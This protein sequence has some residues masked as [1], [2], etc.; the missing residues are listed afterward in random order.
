M[1]VREAAKSFLEDLINKGY[2]SEAEV[3]RRRLH[4]G[5]PLWLIISE[6]TSLETALRLISEGSGVPMLGQHSLEDL[7]DVEAAR[8]QNP[9]T[10]KARRWLPLKDGRVAI[11]EPFGRLPHADLGWRELCLARP[12]DIDTTLNALFPPEKN[13][14]SKMRRLG[15]LLLDADVITEEELARALDEQGRSGGKLG[16]IL[17]SQGAADAVT[18]AGVLAERLG[19]QPAEES[20]IPA[21][22]LPAVKARTWRAVALSSETQTSSEPSNEPLPVAFN[23]PAPEN[24]KAVEEFLRRPVEA[25]LVDKETFNELMGA[26]YAEEDVKGA[27]SGLLESSPH[28]SAFGSRLSGFQAVVGVAL[29]LALVFGLILNF[30]FTAVLITAT[31]SVLYI[32]YSLYRIF[33]AWEGWRAE[34]TLRPSDEQLRSLNERELPVYTILLPVYKEKL[35]TLRALFE[36]LD[37]LDYPKHKLDGILL[38][39]ADDEQTRKAVEEIGRPSWLSTF[40]LPRHRRDRREAGS[41]GRPGWLKVLQVPPGEPRT[42]PKAMIYGLLYARG[43]LITVYD[44]EDQPE[45]RQ[46][47][48]AVWG[49]KHADDS[50]ACLQAKLNYYNARQNLLTRWFALEYSAWFDTFLP[51]LHRLRAPIP[52]GGTSNHFRAD[53]LKES[54]SWD[55]YNVTEDADLGIRLA[56]LGKTTR[57]LHSTTYEEANS[58]FRNWLR[59]RSRWIKG[60]MQ[61]LLVH[62]RNPLQLLRD[63]GPRNTAF[64][65]ATVGGLVYTVLAFPIFWG[66]LVLWFLVQ[67]GWMPQLFPGPVYYLSMFNLF[68]GNFFF[69]LIGLVGAVGRGNDDLSPH[70]LLIPVYWFMMSIAGYLALYELILKPYYWQKTEHGLHLDEEE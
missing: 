35:S 61:T 70:T 28:F 6:E 19:L 69:I 13:E 21:P 46:L 43:D 52:L 40:S 2:V 41:V 42:K 23:D 62:T 47:K 10:L 14:L 48:E 33:T 3:A 66:L 63:V 26:V 67:P 29:V 55:P 31:A 36:A 25:R 11:A 16:E 9:A 51:G 34:S 54:L 15:R 49:F 53:V 12:Q 39:E 4:L 32:L 57:M 44:A 17:V 24:V 60:Y 50:V 59:Q 56:R 20:S 38:V 68:A 65:L 27:V 8:A 37:N 22:I 58:R 18:I 64:F 1:L 5:Y 7:A 45:P 30:F